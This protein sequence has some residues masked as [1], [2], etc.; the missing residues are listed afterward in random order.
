MVDFEAG[1]FKLALL[2]TDAIFS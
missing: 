2:P 1:I